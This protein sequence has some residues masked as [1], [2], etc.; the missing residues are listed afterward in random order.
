M[1]LEDAGDD[2]AGELALVLG[3]HRGQAGGGVLAALAG[4]RVGDLLAQGAQQLLVHQRI[5]CATRPGTASARISGHEVDER[6]REQHRAPHARRG[7]VRS[8]STAL[9]S[10]ATVPSIG[11]GARGGQQPPDVVDGTAVARVADHATPTGSRRDEPSGQRLAQP[12]RAVAQVRHRGDLGADD[13]DD[14]VGPLDDRTRR[15]SPAMKRP[16]STRTSPSWARSVRCRWGQA[17]PRLWRLAR[18]GGADEHVDAVGGGLQVVDQV[19]LVAR[20]D[21]GAERDEAALLVER[22]VVDVAL[23]DG[24]V[25]ADRVEVGHDHGPGHSARPAP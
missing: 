9:G 2:G 17:G 5:S 21:R 19:D 20:A 8:A 14:G 15:A 25:A 6:P 12:R 13:E 4:E 18:A 24:D 7:P 11:P 10:Y 3:G 1:G 23:A 22:V 16:P